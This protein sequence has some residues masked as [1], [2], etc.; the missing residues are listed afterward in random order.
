MNKMGIR[1]A[2]WRRGS[3]FALAQLDIGQE[4]LDAMGKTLMKELAAG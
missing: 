3:E 4:A 1:D 2:E